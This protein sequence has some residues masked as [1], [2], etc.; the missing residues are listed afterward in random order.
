MAEAKD[1]CKKKSAAG[2]GDEEV[3]DSVQERHV[4]HDSE[5]P[6]VVK[7]KTQFLKARIRHF[8]FV[9]L[10]SFHGVLSEAAPDEDPTLV[11]PSHSS[12]K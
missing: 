4:T 3:C 5:Q 10:G 6:C 7:R 12:E 9:H 8:L 2:L 1:N 11:G